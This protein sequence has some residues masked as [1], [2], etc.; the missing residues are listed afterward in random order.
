MGDITREE[1]KNTL[2]KQGLDSGQIHI[3]F[4]EVIIISVATLSLTGGLVSGHLS[5]TAFVGLIGT[6]FGYTFGRIF[7]HVQGKE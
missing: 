7:N 5:E 4:N 6:F 2:H 3:D 1:L